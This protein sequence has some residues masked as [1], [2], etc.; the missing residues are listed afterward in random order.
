[1][2][3]GVDFVPIYPQ[4]L[5]QLPG[6]PMS[7]V[8]AYRE[9]YIKTMAD[10]YYTM[11]TPGHFFE[12]FVYIELLIQFPLAL[13][14]LYWLSTR[15]QLHG[16]GELGAVLYAM[17]TGLCTA[18]VCNDMLYLGPEVISPEAKRTL[19]AAYIPYAIIRESTFVPFLHSHRLTR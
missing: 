15:S 18:T 14:L 2:P 19:F 4:F 13:C 5:H 8:V 7:Y 1:M 11:D 12:F 3:T 16:A 6:S 9:W 17:T 10:P